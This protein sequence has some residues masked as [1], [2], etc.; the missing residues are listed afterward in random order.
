[1]AGVIPNK[2]L[3]TNLNRLATG[4]SGLLKALNVRI[5]DGILRARK[6]QNLI[7]AEDPAFINITPS[8]YDD[9]RCIKLWFYNN[10]P[11]GYF[12]NPQASTPDIFG[13]YDSTSNQW[14]GSL[15]A[16]YG[17]RGFNY[18]NTIVPPQGTESQRR[19]L[20]SSVYGIYSSPKIEDDRII[21]STDETIQTILKYAGAP[22]GLPIVPNSMGG[23]FLI[24]TAATYNANWLADDAAVA[25]RH[26]WKY[27]DVNGKEIYG[28]VSDWKKVIN[29]S[30]G[31]RAVQLEI[32][33][34]PEANGID[35]DRL[36][37]ELYRS[38]QSI[39]GLNGITPP[40]GDELFYC[41]EL[42]PT[43]T[44]LA[45]GYMVHIDILD[46]SALQSPLYTN[47]TQE[48]A[49]SSRVRAPISATIADFAGCAWYGNV[50]ERWSLPF[51]LTSVADTAAANQYGL[52]DSDILVIG[53]FAFEGKTTI[54]LPG[55]S[56]NQFLINNTTGFANTFKRIEKTVENI[57]Y[58]YNTA[59]RTRFN[60]NSVSNPDQIAGS[61]VLQE[62]KDGLVTNFTPY[63]GLYR[64]N[65][66]GTLAGAAPSPISPTP[67]VSDT[68][69]K[70]SKITRIQCAGAAQPISFTC[71]AAP[72]FA[73]GD[74]VNIAAFFK[75]EDLTQAAGSQGDNTRRFTPGQYVVS[76]LV[77]SVFQ[78][79][80]VTGSGAFNQQ[81]GVAPFATVWAAL[82]AVHCVQDQTGLVSQAIGKQQSFPSRV[83]YSAFQE[84]ENAPSLNY[85]DVGSADKAIIKI[86]ALNKFLYVFK[87]DG[88]YRIGGDFPNFYVEQ[89][90]PNVVLFAPDLVCTMGGSL[91]ALTTRG[92]FEINEST[93]RRISKDIQFDLDRICYNNTAY[94]RQKGFGVGNEDDHSVTFWLPNYIITKDGIDQ[95]SECDI[96]FVYDGV[97]W[98]QR[99][100]QANYA[101][102]GRSTLFNDINNGPD[103]YSLYTIKSY[104]TDWL[105]RERK[106]WDGTDYSDELLPIIS[107]QWS[108]NNASNITITPPITIAVPNIIPTGSCVVSGS[109]WDM[110]AFVTGVTDIGSG[111]F[112]LTLEFL[113]P[114]VDAL[115]LDTGNTLNIYFAYELDWQYGINSEDP[116][117]RRHYAD[118]GIITQQPYLSS[119]NAYTSTDIAPGMSTLQD[120]I[121]GFIAVNYDPRGWQLLGQDEDLQD[122]TIKAIIPTVSQRASQLRVGFRHKRACEFV[123]VYGYFVRT[124]EG[125]QAIERNNR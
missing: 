42:R 60:L 21:G 105:T 52:Q 49:Q 36:V 90:D 39:V 32:I 34:P 92:V 74:T 47:E 19:F 57:I 45:N 28:A 18:N 100:D 6:G 61:M 5:E 107:G 12:Q 37:C 108:V 123:S 120:N 50:K 82:G 71:S 65:G 111:Q 51:E 81:I 72:D 20:F 33:I 25:Y 4:P 9:Y 94:V 78:L 64:Q 30:G 125:G 69:G 116:E 70:G 102:A 3:A 96:G 77:G 114:N 43:T 98:T 79:T 24:D 1:M 80:G 99:G 95:S 38:E 22:A 41:V 62:M 86:V 26:V 110:R 68:K 48:G 58:N 121:R 46:D 112:Q 83:M 118:F 76:S 117:K 40:P 73:V 113:D 66:W 13:Y 27:I 63:V 2:Y 119:I 16:D 8:N 97:G 109:D 53:E 15:I 56:N 59:V 23:S 101:C 84:P 106:K 124:V 104:A 31:A 75:Y 54:T 115:D 85:I 29:D 7:I 55:A 35:V 14:Y 88:L 93:V 122:K 44:D 89:F 10:R 103:K 17:D 91:F 67:L 11:F 87:E